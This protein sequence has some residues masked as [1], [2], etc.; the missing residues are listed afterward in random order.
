MS[1]PATTPPEQDTRQNTGTT[2]RREFER[3][4]QEN[5][6]PA[7]ATALRYTGRKD[8]AEDLLQ[9]A[10]IQAY[11]SF[12]SFQQGTNFKAWFL[13]VLTNLYLN[14]R[15]K[16][17][18]QPDTMPL[19]DAPDLYMYTMAKKSGIK[20][21]QWDPT[22]ALLSQL[23]AQQIAAAID[24]LPDEFRMPAFLCFIDELSYSEIA[25]VLGCPV[26]TVRSRL[27]RGRKLLQKSLWELVQPEDAARKP[28]GSK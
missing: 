11:R 18:R 10:A 23:Q 9:E 20:T 19:E 7:Y 21:A 3:L 12:D 17:M 26:G 14:S 13:K 28:D 5:L 25:D 22:G 6:R 27:H 2:R 4:L 8:D 15:R 1:P 16:Q 24:G